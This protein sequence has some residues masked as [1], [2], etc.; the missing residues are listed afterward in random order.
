[1][2]PFGGIARRTLG[3]GRVREEGRL[4]EKVVGARLIRASGPMYSF[5]F[6]SE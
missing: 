5:G 1:M 4:E 2:H 6:H 3:Q